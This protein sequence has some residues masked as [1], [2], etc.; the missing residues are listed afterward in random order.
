MT[1]T[2]LSFSA[3]PQL[4]GSVFVVA[5][6]PR[7]VITALKVTVTP[8]VGGTGASGYS[9]TIER[10]KVIS[11][12][13]AEDISMAPDG[14]QVALVRGPWSIDR[15]STSDL[16]L[17]GRRTRSGFTPISVALGEGGQRVEVYNK[18][19]EGSAQ[20][21]LADGSVARTWS[22][23][24]GRGLYHMFGAVGLTGEDVLALQYRSA[25]WTLHRLPVR[26]ASTLSLTSKKVVGFRK[27]F[28]LGV[29][30]IGTSAR[31][32]TITAKPADRDPRVV[33]TI[34]LDKTGR[35]KLKVTAARNTKFTATVIGDS[36]HLP[37][38]KVRRV[39]VRGPAHFRIAGDHRVVGGYVRLRARETATLVTAIPRS[40]VGS[41]AYVT[42]QYKS[43]G[44]WRLLA[45]TDCMELPE[46]RVVKAKF[47]AYDYRFARDKPLRM[48]SD[49]SGDAWYAG[50]QS[51]WTYA[52]FG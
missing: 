35:G 49:W 33:G 46:S 44:K 37:A 4:P 48:R 12:G 16:S 32:V 22:L 45:G 5:S 30:R 42:I 27:A 23:S 26:F 9:A 2:K 38:S 7:I 20:L 14:S 40:Q 11:G 34:R 6:D 47:R 24:K 43:S 3:S 13:P 52:R 19:E 39:H 51:K 1:V 41:C 10:Q 29:R 36:T 18:N 31:K 17:V 50:S 25:K 15:Y 8:P 28:V 21:I